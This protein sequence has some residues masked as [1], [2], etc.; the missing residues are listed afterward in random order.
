MLT[1]TEKAIFWIPIIAMLVTLVYGIIEL[2]I[3][4]RYFKETVITPAEYTTYAL[5]L[6]LALI[7]TGTSIASL[8]DIKTNKLLM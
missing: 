3:I 8:L 4:P 2:A 6:A 5:T 1:H 7:Y